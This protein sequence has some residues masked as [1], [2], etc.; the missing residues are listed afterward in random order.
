MATKYP[1]QVSLNEAIRIVKDI[2]RIHKSTEISEDLL[3]EIFNVSSRS[4]YFRKTIVAL[5]KFGL[6]DRLPND[7][8]RLTNLAMQ[9]IKPFGNEDKEAKITIAKNDDILAALMEKYPNYVL[10]SPEQTQQTLIKLFDID[11]ETVEKW[12][13]F[14][15]DSFKELKSSHNS[16]VENSVPQDETVNHDQTKIIMPTAPNAQATNNYTFTIPL[17]DGNVISV[18]IPNSA[19]QKDLRKMKAFIDALIDDDNE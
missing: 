2:Y 5:D 16:M 3:P 19:K 6:V 13:L 10:P 12:Y 15:V 11:R 4:S 14:I 8:L 7:I 1:P 9:I 17:S 18:S